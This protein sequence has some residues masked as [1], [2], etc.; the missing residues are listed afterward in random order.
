MKFVPALLDILFNVLFE[1]GCAEARKCLQNAFLV[2][3]MR[4]ASLSPIFFFNCRDGRVDFQR[5][6][7]LVPACGALLYHGTIQWMV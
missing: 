5:G 4:V 6:F 3:K 1:D 2:T 7:L